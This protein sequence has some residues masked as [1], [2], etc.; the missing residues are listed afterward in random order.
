MYE[1][2]NKLVDIINK[3]LSEDYNKIEKIIK[4]NE[5]FINLDMDEQDL[6]LEE[7]KEK[8]TEILEKKKI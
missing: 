4:S 2:F 7:A 3:N 1:L 5:L 6:L 8:H